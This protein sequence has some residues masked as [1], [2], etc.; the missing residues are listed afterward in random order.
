M[1]NA[2]V[3]R[4][5]GRQGSKEVGKT[6][7][8]FALVCDKLD[9]SEDTLNSM[10][11]DIVEVMSRCLEIETKGVKLEICRTKGVTAL[12]PGNRILEPGHRLKPP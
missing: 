7:L 11:R 12:V 6:R 8:R 2:L 9:L 10:Q 5:K 4:L 1:L 3:K